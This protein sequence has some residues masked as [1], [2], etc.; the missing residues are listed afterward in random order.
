MTPA[1][2]S[3]ALA[4]ASAIGDFFALVPDHSGP[5]WLRLDALLDPVVLEA[6]VAMTTVAIAGMARLEPTAIQPRVAA[7]TVSLGMFARVLAP[8]FGAL[9]ATGVLPEVSLESLWWQPVLGGA[10]PLSLDPVPGGR[11]GMNAAA[12]FDDVVLSQVM[13]PLVA[14]F[15]RAGVSS[16]V[17]LGNVASALGGAARMIGLARPEVAEAAWSLVGELLARPTLAGTARLEA[18]SLQRNSCCLF[19]RVPGGGY[20]GD[21][22][23]RDRGALSR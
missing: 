10:V 15:R 3:H 14:A 6:R 21:C 9:V 18:A 20:C 11:P 2:V 5:G 22:I 12:A 1:E 16:V 7:S 13:L 17:L 19:Y 4:E 23:L 8:P